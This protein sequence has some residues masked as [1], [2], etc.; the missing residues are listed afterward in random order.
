MTLRD[1][2]QWPS[3]RVHDIGINR[4][5]EGLGVGKMQDSNYVKDFISQVDDNSSDQKICLYQDNLT[6]E[7]S[8]NEV[9]IFED[10]TES[11]TCVLSRE[12]L[13]EILSGWYDF[14]IAYQNGKIPGIYHPEKG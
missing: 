4:L 2:S 9:K 12:K 8:G 6:L 11:E 5:V 10:S 13:L 14:L 7:I 1:G 3:I